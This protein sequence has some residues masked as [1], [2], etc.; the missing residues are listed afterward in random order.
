MKICEFATGKHLLLDMYGADC[1]SDSE[2]IEKSLI[3]AAKICGA[4][5]L[6]SH[7]HHFGENM[8]VTGVVLLAESHMSIHTWPENNFAAI[9]LFMCGSCNPEKAIVPLRNAFKPEKLDVSCHDRGMKG[10]VA[11]RQNIV[12]M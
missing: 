4:T 11:L 2:Y 12:N 5:V 10:P 1:L 6:N 8:G 3:N 9:D 7:F